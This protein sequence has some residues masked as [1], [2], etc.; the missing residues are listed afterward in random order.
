MKYFY[1]LLLINYCKCISF[2]KNIYLKQ[3]NDLVK[4]DVSVWSKTEKTQ[5]FDT[6]KYNILQE[7]F[8]HI[9]RPITKD[10]ILEVDAD[11]VKDQILKKYK[12]KNSKKIKDLL[13][14]SL[15]ES[16]NFSSIINEIESIKGVKQISFFDHI[17]LKSPEPETQIIDLKN[18]KRKLAESKSFPNDPAFEQYQKH[19][20]S[21]INHPIIKTQ[22]YF[23]G[24]S[25]SITILDDSIDTY[26]SDLE[27]NNINI[28]EQNIPVATWNSPYTHGTRVVGII[29]AKTNNNIDIA[30]A[31]SDVNIN[32]L[33]FYDCSYTQCTMRGLSE[34]F[35]NII[36][37]NN[38]E[39]KKSIISNSWGSIGFVGSPYW[40]SNRMYIEQ[41][42]ETFR[43]GN[44]GILVFSSGNGRLET[45]Y[46][47]YSLA[48]TMINTITVG[49]LYVSNSII[50]P[51]YFS[52]E[53]S[54]LTVSAPGENIYSLWPENYI[55]SSSGTSFAAP[56][57][58]SAISMLL[59]K[60][61]DLRNVDVISL[62]MK[63]ASKNINTSFSYNSKGFGYSN[64]VGAGILNITKLME[65]S[66][67]WVKLEPFTIDNIESKNIGVRILAPGQYIEYEFD[68]NCD[69]NIEAQS[70]QVKLNAHFSWYQNFK[71]ELVSPSGTVSQLVNYHDPYETTINE[72]G[73]H[74]S[75]VEEYYRKRSGGYSVVP[76]FYSNYAFKTNQ[77]LE[78]NVKGTWKVKITH[79]GYLD[80][81]NDSCNYSN[82]NVCDDLYIPGST[83]LCSVGTDCKDCTSS[84][85]LGSTFRNSYIN[86]TIN[87]VKIKV[88]GY[89]KN[90]KSESGSD[91][92]IDI[93]SLPDCTNILETMLSQSPSYC[94]N[95]NILSNQDVLCTCLDYYKGPANFSCNILPQLYSPINLILENCR[96]RIIT[97][98]INSIKNL[99]EECCGEDCIV[100]LNSSNYNVT[101]S[102]TPYI[103]ESDVGQTPSQPPP[104][105]GTVSLQIYGTSFSDNQNR[106]KLFDIDWRPMYKNDSWTD[107]ET[108]RAKAT[109]YETTFKVIKLCT[110]YSKDFGV[111]S[112]VDELVIAENVSLN[113]AADIVSLKIN[114]TIAKNY[115]YTYAE[116]SR[117]VRI[118]AKSSDSIGDTTC[119]TSNSSNIE[120]A[121]SNVTLS[122]AF[123]MYAPNSSLTT[124]AEVADVYFYSGKG[125]EQHYVCRDYTC[126]KHWSIPAFPTDPI[127]HSSNGTRQIGGSD[128]RMLAIGDI[129][130]QNK[131]ISAVLEVIG[132]ITP[133]TT[134][135]KLE[136]DTTY[137]AIFE[138]I[139]DVCTVSSY[140]INIRVLTSSS[141]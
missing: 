54:C 67:K 72:N 52:E 74:N 5:F 136:W 62:L 45:N 25:V 90:I 46:A 21:S 27:R 125:E 40:E 112:C 79:G 8:D 88:N 127:K 57:V 111:L 35:V 116:L 23:N 16:S 15:K 124:N 73:L 92:I 134:N 91:N 50:E 107:W 75:R 128:T 93:L 140:A 108:S 83:P 66:E 105:S 118:Q 53:C 63:S 41:S 126:S 58:S 135:I 85:Y 4:K 78:E 10:I 19:I 7:I 115:R 48:N 68:V 39:D 84:H 99:Q 131:T 11:D 102:R 98:D 17:P 96:T 110:N 2:T 129:Y 133:S 12:I 65:I 71:L 26:H 114:A 6:N 101:Y 103:S 44:G 95:T 43:N 32:F 18:D 81:C 9:P 122:N 80:T 60:Y 1:C 104:S 87:H 20:Y 28:I 120:N 89:T 121:S 70:I 100:R 56:F 86:D 38:Y 37:T 77:F 139:R 30:G 69:E 42:V 97:I 3:N 106:R 82:N 117:H 123:G 76:W 34:L 33:S 22:N 47:H 109:Y 141:V 61:P 130:P 59:Q 113:V 119:F 36:L 13:I 49:S 55:S 14:I 137:G 51:S 29:A 24:S 138:H 64:R 94:N 31:S 132:E